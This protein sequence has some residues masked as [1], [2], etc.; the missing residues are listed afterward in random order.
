MPNPAKAKATATLVDLTRALRIRR[1][2]TPAPAPPALWTLPSLSGSL[3][4][5]S[6]AGSAPVLTLAFSLVLDA[7]RAGEPVAWITTPD[8]SFYP[9]DAAAGGVDLD[10]LVV[11]RLAEMRMLA[12]AADHLARSGAFGLL[13]LDLASRE[14]RPR[15][16]RRDAQIPI[17]MQSRLVSLA[18]KHD[19]VVL[20]LTHKDDQAPSLGSLVSV[21]GQARRSDF[22]CEVQVIKDKRRGPGWMHREV[23]RGPDGLC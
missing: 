5:L 15:R 17:P 1:G 4:E 12:R 21:R 11:V 8:S 19:A 18:Q 13:V 16:N 3:V 20:C 10:S 2:G 23:C 22:A 7:Q 9:P 6:G 14:H